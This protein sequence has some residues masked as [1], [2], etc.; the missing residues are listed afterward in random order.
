MS[1]AM[2][3]SKVAS[4]LF[5]FG[6]SCIGIYVAKSLHDMSASV[7]ELNINVAVV[8]EKV[9]NHERRIEML[10]ERGP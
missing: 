9:S 2:E 7:Q 1:D 6:W 5:Y 4:G 3:W 10:E 8:I